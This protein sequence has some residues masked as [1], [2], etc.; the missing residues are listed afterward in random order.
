M[1]GRGGVVAVNPASW[2]VAPIKATFFGM[3][4]G[5]LTGFAG[6]VGNTFGY[7]DFQVPG[8]IERHRTIMHAQGC[9]LQ[10]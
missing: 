10:R 5:I 7:R 2:N 4:K 9:C 1:S 6:V 8:N 3:P